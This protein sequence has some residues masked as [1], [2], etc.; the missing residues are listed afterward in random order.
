MDWHAMPPLAALRAFEAAAEA[1]SFTAA[2]ERLGVTHAAVVQQVRGLERH[3]GIALAVREGRGLALTAEGKD[4]AAALSEGFGRIAAEIAA[5]R[6]EIEGAPL[7]IT[8]TPS[9]ASSWLV[10]RL[11]DF[12]EKH[13][14]IALSLHPEHAHIDLVRERMD[15]AIRFGEG[16]WPGLE[17]ELL[18]PGALVLVAAA[19]LDLGPPLTPAK[20]QAQDWVVEQNRPEQLAYMRR[21]GVK[22]ESLDLT[23]MPNEELAQEAIAAGLGLGVML[24]ALADGDDRLQILQESA[25]SRLGYWLCWP[26]GHERPALRT[27]LRWLRSQTTHP[28]LA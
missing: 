5:L 9:F 7:R 25:G 18:L 15:L 17:S 4:L 8:M 14:D 21:L 12:W 23:E 2:A 16:R 27:F 26:K 24:K 20:L 11:G 10:P 3:L 28:D 6:A 1:K 13:S 22:P 19:S